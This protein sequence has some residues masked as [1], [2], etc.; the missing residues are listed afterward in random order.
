MSRRSKQETATSEIPEE[1][2]EELVRRIQEQEKDA[3]RTMTSQPGVVLAYAIA[4]DGRFGYVVSELELPASVVERYCTKRHSPDVKALA[5][6][7]VKSAIMRNV[8]QNQP[9]PTL[10]GNLLEDDE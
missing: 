3:K 10:S 2:V 8:T 4:H 5:I 1:E 9:K 7:R 6:E